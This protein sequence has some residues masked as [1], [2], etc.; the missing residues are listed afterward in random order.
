MTVEDHPLYPK[1]RNALELVI[2]TKEVR[3]S[4][5]QGTPQWTAAESN[6]QAALVA[7]DLIAREI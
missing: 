4:C 3:N 6:Y 1:W 5:R 2:A 7:Y